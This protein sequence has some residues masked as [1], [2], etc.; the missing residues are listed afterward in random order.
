MTK[1]E[2]YVQWYRTGAGRAWYEK[3]NRQRR[4]WLDMVKVAFGC[5]DCGYDDNP[6]ALEF[7]HIGPRGDKRH[8]ISTM[9]TGG[10]GALLAELEKCEVRCA[11]CHSIASHERNQYSN[12]ETA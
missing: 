6:R 5:F 4:E 1:R 11:N 7:D 9:V 10:W 12:R 3:R 2:Q 8:C